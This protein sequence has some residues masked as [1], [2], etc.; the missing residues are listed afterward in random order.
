MYPPAG[1][2]ESAKGDGGQGVLPPAGPG[3]GGPSPRVPPA[4]L[5]PGDPPPQTPPPGQGP[6]EETLQ[7]TSRALH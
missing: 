1:R 5:S 6:R 7:E 3:G 2:A 4:P